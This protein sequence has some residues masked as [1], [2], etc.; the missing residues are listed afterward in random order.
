MKAKGWRIK[1]DALLG[2][3][4]VKGGAAGQR[5][6]GDRQCQRAA[7]LRQFSLC[8][9]ETLAKIS[10]RDIRIQAKLVLKRQPAARFNMELSLEQRV[11]LSACK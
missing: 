2:G 5:I 1:N 3:L 7:A 6:V 4:Y 9:G 11:A 8:L 10:G